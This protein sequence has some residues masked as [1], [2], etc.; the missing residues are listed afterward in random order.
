M[1]LQW[2]VQREVKDRG[3]NVASISGI[4]LFMHISLDNC[5]MQQPCCMH[6]QFLLDMVFGEVYF[7]QQIFKDRMAGHA[8]KRQQECGAMDLR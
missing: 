2:E 4:F 7:C 6:K 8:G 5:K 3:K 1:S